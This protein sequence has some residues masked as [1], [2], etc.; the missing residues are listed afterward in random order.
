[1][2]RQKVASLAF[3]FL[4][5]LY[6]SSYSR[7]S[8]D[9]SDDYDGNWHR[10]FN[11]CDENNDNLYKA[12]QTSQQSRRHPPHD[13][14]YQPPHYPK[15]EFHK[16]PPYLMLD[17][18]N[19]GLPNTFSPV[20]VISATPT[21]TLVALPPADLAEGPSDSSQPATLT[22]SPPHQLPSTGFKGGVKG[23]LFME[24]L[25]KQITPAVNLMGTN[26]NLRNLVWLGVGTQTGS[27]GRQKLILQGHTAVSRKDHLAAQR[28]QQLLKAKKT[29]IM[30]SSEQSKGLWKRPGHHNTIRRLGIKKDLLQSTPS[31]SKTKAINKSTLKKPFVYLKRKAKSN[32]SQ[33]HP[34]L[35]EE[36]LINKQQAT[37]RRWCDS[38]YPLKF[39][40]SRSSSGSLSRN[41]SRTEGEEDKTFF[42]R[43]ISSSFPSKERRLIDG[44][45]DS[46][47][48]TKVLIL[49]SRGVSG[50]NKDGNSGNIG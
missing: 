44:H 22:V 35:R 3:A 46:T 20:T 15:E 18:F 50:F 26:D 1:M 5:L 24:R 21:N 47:D 12:P 17:P 10:Y 41:K 7:F 9:I 31:N 13:E 28:Q 38:P 29:V 14:F 19:P 25:S 33:N 42:C 43:R 30:K 40:M 23:P 27:D 48:R 11:E 45:N 16:Q 32:E 4:K 49:E 36:K 34:Q 39:G 6:W 37:V 2:E 8:L